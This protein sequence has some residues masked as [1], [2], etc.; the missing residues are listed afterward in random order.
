MEAVKNYGS[1]LYYASE[2]LRNNA[3]IVI[4][5]IKNNGMALKYASDELKNNEKIVQ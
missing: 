5:A 3:E 1:S 2:E 4:E